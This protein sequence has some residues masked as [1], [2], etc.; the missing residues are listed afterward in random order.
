[1]N[2]PDQSTI[3]HANQSIDEPKRRNADNAKL[4]K[5]FEKYTE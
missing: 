2:I 5:N 4:L 3:L 1:M